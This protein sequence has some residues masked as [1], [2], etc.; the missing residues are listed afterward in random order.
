MMLGIPL[1]PT[2]LLCFIP[3]PPIPSPILGMSDVERAR[4]RKLIDWLIQAILII[5]KILN[6]FDFAQI[7][8]G[9]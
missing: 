7:R 2:L 5:I 4:G 6:L 8:I 9:I 3:F 1:I